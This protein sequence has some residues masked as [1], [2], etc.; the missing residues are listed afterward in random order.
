MIYKRA[1]ILRGLTM[2]PPVWDWCTAWLPPLAHWPLDWTGRHGAPGDSGRGW[3]GLT[4][5]TVSPGP[6]HGPQCRDSDTQGT[7]SRGQSPPSDNTVTRRV[8]QC[9]GELTCSQW[10]GDHW[11]PRL[12]RP[13]TG[14]QA[15][16]APGISHWIWQLEWDQSDQ[17]DDRGVE[18]SNNDQ[19]PH[20]GPH[21][22]VIRV[23]DRSEIC[24]WGK[25]T[26]QSQPRQPQA[27]W[28]NQAQ[29]PA[30]ETQTMTK[31]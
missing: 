26:Q 22:T 28:Q 7:T 5:A 6:R 18:R 23:S 15:I 14:T 3:R 21:D 16:V 11:D 19:W 9:R 4:V 31:R 13:E 1:C 20:S 24:C 17:S 2:V 8:M 10:P 29:Q 12:I 25:Q 27:P 30:T